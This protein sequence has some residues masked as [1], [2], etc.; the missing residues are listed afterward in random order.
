MAPNVLKG[1]TKHPFS[2]Q[3]CQQGAQW[4]AHL[5]GRSRQRV[6]IAHVR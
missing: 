2:G 1:D 5:V 3:V 4:G 6:N